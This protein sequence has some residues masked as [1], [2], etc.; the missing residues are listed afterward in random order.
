MVA[1]LDKEDQGGYLEIRD[2]LRNEL[3]KNG[4]GVIVEEADANLLETF[5]EGNKEFDIQNTALVLRFYLNFC[6]DA[7]EARSN[8]HYDVI[9]NKF[10]KYVETKNGKP[11]DSIELELDADNNYDLSQLP[12]YREITD[13]LKTIKLRIEND[14]PG[15]SLL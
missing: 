11:I 8:D 1:T 6:M 13:L 4:F 9:L 2:H 7:L 5:F 3:I 10:N 14:R 15:N 12:S